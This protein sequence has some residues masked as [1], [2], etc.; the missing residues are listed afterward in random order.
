MEDI[1]KRVLLKPAQCA[2]DLTDGS[3]RGPY[4]NQDYIIQRLQRPHRAVN[5]MYC[6]YP[7]DKGWP[8]RA[9]DAYS[10]MNVDFA[11]AYP[12]DNYFPYEGGI[13]GNRNGEPFKSIRD[14]RKHGQDVILTL[15]CD[16]TISDASIVALAEDLK[17]FGRLILRLN[18]E[19][20]GNWFS[21]TKRA[22]P[23][24][25]SDFFVR[26]KKIFSEQ[27]PNIRLLLCAGA[28]ESLKDAAVEKEE[29][30]IEAI[31]AA[32]MWSIDKY[33]ALNWGWPYEIAEKDN[34]AHKLDSP[35]LVYELARKTYKRY[36]EIDN[37][38]E[39]KFSMAEL[40]ADGDVTGQVLQAAYMERFCNLIKN[41][42]EPFLGSFCLYQFRDDGRLGLEQTDPNNPEVGIEQPLMKSYRTIIHDK[43]FTP[44][45]IEKNQVRLPYILR[46]GG[47]E[48]AEGV[49][50]PI[51]IESLPVFAELYFEGPL[52]SANFMFEL[53]G[54]WFYKAPGVKSIDLM[55]AFF[56]YK[57]NRPHVWELRMF[58][59]PAFGE[60]V[61]SQGSDW[62][63]NYYY[64][65]RGIPKLRMRFE[66]VMVL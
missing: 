61:S 31:K 49:S 44:E 34:T 1:I 30:F 15:A 56:G 65:L 10:G 50:I 42:T 9:Q 55:P 43:F 41:D 29:D 39:K 45:I 22:T 7:K 60:N 18:H 24:Q 28:V 46:W 2:V 14:I 38:T 51:E 4:V 64:T 21:F 6:Y 11:W 54:R 13:G 8:K 35:E 23:K 57:V 59:P 5:L 17:P 32:D 26:F 66:P 52:L 53:N 33:I 63:E 27:A 25:L 19:C 16:P 48:D 40:N 37:G 3:E 58:A 20:T 62:A 36:L 12:Y 47:S